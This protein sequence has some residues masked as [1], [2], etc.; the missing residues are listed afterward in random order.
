[1][2]IPDFRKRGAVIIRIL[3]TSQLAAQPAPNWYPTASESSDIYATLKRPSSAVPTKNPS[4][5][6]KMRIVHNYLLDLSVRAFHSLKFVY[7]S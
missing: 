1:M 4:S 5:R 2:K 3:S 7:F 6:E